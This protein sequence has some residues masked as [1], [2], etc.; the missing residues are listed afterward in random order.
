MDRL[1][2]FMILSEIEEVF[3]MTLTE[4]LASEVRPALGCTEPG[5]VALAVARA[6]RE[7]EG[8]PESLT[9][10]VSRSIYKNGVAVG[11]PGTDGLK[12]NDIAAALAMTCGNPDYGLEVLKDCP[13]GQ[14]ERAE[15][16]LDSGRIRIV[17]DM[18]RHGVYVSAEAK[19]DHEN[20]VCVI[21]GKHDNIVRVL[22]NG[23]PVFEAAAQAGGS[24]APSVPDQMAKLTFNEAVSIADSMTDG[25]VETLM[26]GV[27]MNLKM[28]RYGLEHEAGLGVGRM[29][30]SE[31]RDEHDI[32]LKIK[33]WTA[34]A[35][36]ARMSGVNMAVMSSAGSG[37]H[38]LTAIIPVALLAEKLGC[39]RKTTAHAVAFSHLVTS[40]IK[41]RIGR[42]SPICG[43]TVSAGAGASA[44]M[45]WL[46]TGEASKA[47][48][49][50]NLIL[51]NLAGMVCDGAKE[52]CALK[53]GSGSIEAYHASLLA[54][55][56][57]APEKQGLVARTVEQS[58]ENLAS[59]SNLGMPDMDET[60]IAILDC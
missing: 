35:A 29:V 55:Q 5:A 45:T 33:A 9:V 58:V 18:S 38:G 7:I 59:M 49:A 1:Y 51:S 34:A 50:V 24:S 44:A 3:V 21:E 39:D 17:A 10:T 28:A 37:N 32:G 25:D 27:E 54:A 48:Q 57:C 13:C 15:A 60:L 41:S 40:F 47:A 43:C 52:T 6:C 2:M 8:E 30:A 56:G 36:D 4:F 22:H 31:M 14:A 12:G 46:K 23:A 42:L 19:T 20:A 26:R 11:I 53:V 16:L